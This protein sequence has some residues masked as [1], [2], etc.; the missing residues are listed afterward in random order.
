MKRNVSQAVCLLLGLHFLPFIAAQVKAAPNERGIVAPGLKPNFRVLTQ[1]ERELRLA[2]I[3]AGIQ[4]SLRA[5]EKQLSKPD[6]TPTTRDL[7]NAALA[8]LILGEDARAAE[9]LVLQA[10]A[11]QDLDPHSPRYGAL[12]WQIGNPQIQDEN[13]NMFGS[14]AIGP[15]LVEYGNRLSP[16]FKQAMI[17]HI[18][19]ICAAMQRR[20]FR[21]PSYTNIFLMRAVNMMLLGEVIG[22]KQVADDGYTQFDQWLA[23]TRQ[24]GIHEFDSPTY[25]GVD[26][27]CLGLGYRYAARP[28]AH[29]KFRAA[30]DYFWSDI[31]ANFFAPN[32]SLAGP[33]SRNYDFLRSSGG[34][35]LYLYVAGLR[36]TQNTS[37]LD[38]EKTFLLV[39][40]SGDKGYHPDAQVLSLSTLPERTVLQKWETA[41][42]AVRYNYIT[43]DFA[44]G[45]T[46]ANYGAQDKL[47]T[48]E[49]ASP[50]NLPVISVVPDSFDEPYGKLKTP[51]RSGHN[52]PT[53]L[54][55]SPV[56]VQ[57]KGTLLAL[58][59]LDAS[60]APDFRGETGTLATNVLLPLQADAI[61]VDGVAVLPQTITEHTAHLN[62]VLGL[63]AGKTGVAIRIFRADGCARQEPTFTLKTDQAGV[64]AEVTRYVVY[65]YR[66]PAQKL[67]EEH[68]RVGLLMLAAHCDNDNDFQQLLQTV[69]NAHIEEQDD[70]TTWRV[71]A[72]IGNLS[73]A[74]ARDL[75]HRTLLYRRINGQ[76]F[77]PSNLSVN[78][79]DLAAQILH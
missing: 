74:A 45:S 69:Q 76:D 21:T 19:G 79:D 49:L 33:H 35:D 4:T 16:N 78:G 1:A 75:A 67:K 34:L 50:K 58:L 48:V 26:L 73:L 70:Q 24:N 32:G 44:I 39:N 41:P 57:A 63:R 20:N 72:Q 12:P 3:R 7:T 62:S 25:Y 40:L 77:Q 10:Y 56:A 18:Q 17:P 29:A 52:K 14:Q 37:K 6:A 43:P 61:T 9:Q 23:Y 31:A 36:N 8:K 13:A 54:P 28:E 47:L 65:H 66:G 64:Q 59:D 42:G 27:N 11:Q 22:D 55:L 46:S 38:F 53:H 15:M 5:F 60:K 2:H 30:L 71:T 51:D 68:L